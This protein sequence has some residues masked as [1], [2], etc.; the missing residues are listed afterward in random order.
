M[1]MLC[2]GSPFLLDRHG[3]RQLYLGVIGLYRFSC[4]GT[5][6]NRERDDA[7]SFKNTLGVYRRFSL[8]FCFKQRA[9]HSLRIFQCQ[10]AVSAVAWSA[11]GRF[12]FSGERTGALRL[13][14]LD[15]D[16]QVRSETDWDEGARP[17]LETFLA[18][19]VPYAAKLRRPRRRYGRVEKISEWDLQQA[20]TRRGKPAWT[21]QDFDALIQQ[22]QCAG[23]GWLRPEGVRH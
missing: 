2:H 14:E 16:L 10:G 4:A 1:R 22:L 19:H 18:L 13:W 7:F 23:Y 11:D 17:Y 12:F 5:P 20:L 8:Q 6:G 9:W 3:A 21:E 15:W